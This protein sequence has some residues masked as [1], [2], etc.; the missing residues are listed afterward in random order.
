MVQRPGD[1]LAAGDVAHVAGTNWT[2]IGTVS[3]T[4]TLAKDDQGEVVALTN[5]MYEITPHD[6]AAEPVTLNET[7]LSHET[8][9]PA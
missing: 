3:G 4:L 5:G 1:Q 6:P 2:V 7:D 9:E 8:S